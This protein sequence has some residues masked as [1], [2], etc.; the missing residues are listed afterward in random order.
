VSSP[1]WPAPV[2]QAPVN[3]VVRVPGS[4][5][6]TNRALVLAALADGPSTISAPLRSR[7]TL[8]MA[9]ALRALGVL[10]EDVPVSDE[11]GGDD[12]GRDDL[13]S[14]DPP[15]WRVTPPQVLRGGAVVDCGLAGT[16]M[17][18]VPPVAALA[19]GAVRLD[20]DPRARE[21][22]M[23]PVLSS[24]RALGAE[25]DDGGRAALPFTVKGD[26]A[27][28]GGEVEVDASASSQFISALLLAGAR[29]TDGLTLRHVGATLP[30]RP[31]IDMTLDM[32]T[33]RGVVWREPS[34]ACWEVEPGPVRAVD[35]VVEPDLSNASPFLA[36]AL[37]TGGR[38]TIPGWPEH[39]TQAGAESARLLERMG[40]EVTRDAFGLTVHGG[41]RPRGADLDLGDVGELV[42]T[43][44]AVAALAD[45]PT[46]LRG[47]AHLRGHETDR[48]A[49]LVTEINRLGGDAEETADG[50]VVRPRPLH[51]GTWHSY[52]DH[53]MATAGAIIGLVVP[54]VEVEDVA[55]T[56]K[57]LPDFPGMW[58]AMLASAQARR[59]AEEGR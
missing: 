58:A 46:T 25:I 43:I 40:A 14:D 9:D 30:S 41:T 13:G 56:A 34:T 17:R 15:S 6:I 3:A 53:R 20:G 4:K 11:P 1:S 36:A 10:V 22:P 21:R 37:V 51:G 35:E 57:T 39:T 48:L 7:D 2:A 5:S 8:L 52:A 33:A 24:L 31:H 32:L 28:P 54:G 23:G 26:G 38:V 27:L 18:F 55:T 45:S 16:V 49:A 59:R 42:P 29:F 44:A 19:D 12:L 50:L 47:V